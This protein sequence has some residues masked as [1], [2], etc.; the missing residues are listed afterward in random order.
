MVNDIVFSLPPT[1][2]S[3]PTLLKDSPCDKL[4]VRQTR[5]TADSPNDSDE[6]DTYSDPNLGFSR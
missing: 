2:Y 5:H 4:A 3:K 1:E 6:P